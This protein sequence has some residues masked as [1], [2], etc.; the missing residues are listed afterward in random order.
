M[1]GTYGP[2]TSPAPLERELHAVDGEAAGHA[3]AHAPRKRPHICF[4]AHTTW[5]VFSGSR[6][7]PVIGGAELQQSVIARA[8]AAR[9]YRV[10][11][12]TMDYGQHDGTVLDGVTVHKIHTPDEGIPV[13]RVVQ[14]RLTSLW[15][16]M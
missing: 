2:A 3:G 9:G 11:M 12:I 13:V 1:P 5:P 14:P 8:L 6:D 15:G 7:I 10:S 4:V 16:A